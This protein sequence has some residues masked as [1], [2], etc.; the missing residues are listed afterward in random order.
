MYICQNQSDEQLIVSPDL[1]RLS[2]PITQDECLYDSHWTKEADNLFID[3]LIESHLLG[4]WSSGRPGPAVFG[5]CRTIFIYESEQT[6]SHDEFDERF[7]FLQKRDILDILPHATVRTC[8]NH[9]PLGQIKLSADCGIGALYIAGRVLSLGPLSCKLIGARYYT[10]QRHWCQGRSRTW[11]PHGLDGGR[12]PCGQHELLRHSGRDGQGRGPM[13]SGGGVQSV[14]DGEVKY[15]SISIGSL[16]AANKGI[17]TVHSAGNNGFSPGTVTSV[18]PW[19]FTVGASTMDRGIVTKLPLGD[20]KIFD[21]K[22]VNPF[23]MKGSSE[24]PLVYGKDVTSSCSETN[25]K[26]RSP[27]CLNSSLVT[28]KIVLCDDPKGIEEGLNAGAAGVVSKQGITPDV[29]FVVP[30]PATTLV[31]DNLKL[32]QD[33][34][35]STKDAKASIAISEPI[36]NTDAPLVASFSSKGP[37]I[38]V[39]DILKPDITDPGVEIFAAYSPEAPASN[40]ASDKRSVKYNILSGT[41]M[42]C[43]HVTGAAAYVKSIHPDWSF[44]NQICSN[45]NR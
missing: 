27:G 42:S 31:A 1:P 35:N 6:V 9:T 28:G 40:Y 33:Y 38:I 20:G 19:I 4:K 24:L 37:N 13:G 16:H 2:T 41:S 3:L 45:D 30:L 25:A 14:L 26:L 8:P 5:Y 32:V 39:H 23:K 44:C 34:V 22:A 15:D 36:K 29:S 11:H 12:K 10:L 18:A 21:G 17:L 7:N 43:P